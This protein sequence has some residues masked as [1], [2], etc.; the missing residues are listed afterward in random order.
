MKIKKKIKDLF[1]NASVYCLF[2]R[3]YTENI[4]EVFMSQM[5]LNFYIRHLWKDSTIFFFRF[6]FSN[7]TIWKYRIWLNIIRHTNKN[8]IKI[9][10]SLFNNF[11]INTWINVKT[12]IKKWRKWYL[13]GKLSRLLQI[14]KIWSICT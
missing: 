9:A 13:L 12:N 1:K 10:T 2:K 11:L 6:Y 4:W 5:T 3:I 14:I 8:K 7:P